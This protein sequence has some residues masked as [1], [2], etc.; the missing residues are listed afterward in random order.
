MEQSNNTPNLRSRVWNLIRTS[1]AVRGTT[2]VSCAALALAL[3]C[4][5]P[6]V[7]EAVMVDMMDAPD[8]REA[9]ALHCTGDDTGPVLVARYDGERVS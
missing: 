7:L 5:A 9:P 4:S 1:R 2:A 8:G 6:D 3:G